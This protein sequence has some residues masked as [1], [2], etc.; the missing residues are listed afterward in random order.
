MVLNKDLYIC[1]YQKESFNDLKTIN[2]VIRFLTKILINISTG[3]H[4][5]F[6]LKLSGGAGGNNMSFI[7]MKRKMEIKTNKVTVKLISK[8]TCMQILF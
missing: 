5:I 8:L 1:M 6:R 2:K 3:I 7:K 4:R